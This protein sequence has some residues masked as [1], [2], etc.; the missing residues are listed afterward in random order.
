MRFQS[1]KHI[2]NL[3]RTVST[4][5]EGNYRREINDVARVHQELANLLR[6]EKSIVILVVG[7]NTNSKRLNTLEENMVSDGFE[8]K[9]IKLPRA[10]KI[11]S[12]CGGKATLIDAIW[13]I[14]KTKQRPKGYVLF[15]QDMETVYAF[16]RHKDL[17]RE[18]YPIYFSRAQKLK[19]EKKKQAI[20]NHKD[21]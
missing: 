3:G 13:N 11:S 20:G 1:G 7:A 5:M 6:E 19:D 2:E 10:V 15:P 18:I 8:Y 12:V 21:D 16:E 14:V 17:C 9:E 4:I